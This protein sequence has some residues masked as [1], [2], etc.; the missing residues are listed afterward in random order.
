MNV[1]RVCFY[2][3]SLFPDQARET[4]AVENYA[5]D[6]DL[7]LGGT[8]FHKNMQCFFC[9]CFFWLNYYF[10]HVCTHAIVTFL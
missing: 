9:G 4:P 7:L 5:V 6:P 8:E 10:F 1:F 3:C 2:S